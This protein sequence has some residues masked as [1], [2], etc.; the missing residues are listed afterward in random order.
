MRLIAAFLLFVSIATAS[1][2]EFVR[3]W[4]QW[5]EAESFVRISEYFGSGENTG[6]QTMLR[7]QPQER[8]GFY[9]LTRTRNESSAWG[10][11]KFVL[12]II[13]PD[14]PKPKTFEFSTSVPQ[15]GHVFNLG[16][17]GTDWANEET[18]PVAWRLRLMSSDGKEL[19]TQQSFLWA[20]P[21]SG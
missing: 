19:A 5:R 20:L 3:V 17:T 6:R 10:D 13:T 2:V 4:P 18:H 1:E 15:G 14:S 9:F 11:A 16:L 12:E 21:E 7:S 8:T